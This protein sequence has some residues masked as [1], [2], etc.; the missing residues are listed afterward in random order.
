[1]CD[2]AGV[3]VLGVPVY[4]AVWF[5][6]MAQSAFVWEPSPYIWTREMIR[7]GELQ[8]AIERALQGRA[9]AEQAIALGQ[10]AATLKGG[11]ADRPCS[12]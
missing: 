3:D 10:V 5:P 2:A 12:A 11:D 7:A 6:Q 9:R 4:F 1:V 8:Y